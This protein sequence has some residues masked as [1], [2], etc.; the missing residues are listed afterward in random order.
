[1]EQDKLNFAKN[2]KI[3]EKGFKT[4]KKML[5][6]M[7][8]AFAVPGLFVIIL[9][10]VFPIVLTIL[11]FEV[12]LYGSFA[13]YAHLCNCEDI[14]KCNVET[15]NFT[16]KDYKQMKKSGE[17]VR[18]YQQIEEIKNKQSEEMYSHYSEFIKNN[19]NTTIKTSSFKNN[20]KSEVK[21]N[22]SMNEIDKNT[23]YSSENF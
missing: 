6:D 10:T 20:N 15:T 8:I 22:D 7:A 13:T 19:I 4:R 14:K 9:S 17:L 16:Y 1:M 3:A 12:L 21:L 18:L 2:C 11:A 23:H 5:K